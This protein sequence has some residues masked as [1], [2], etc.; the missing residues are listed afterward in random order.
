MEFTLVK[1]NMRQV[2][3]HRDHCMDNFLQS[4]QAVIEMTPGID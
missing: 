1:F 4:T 2:E 3:S